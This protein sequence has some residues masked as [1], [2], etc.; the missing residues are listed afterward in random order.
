[1]KKLLTLGLF[2]ILSLSVVG[3]G[4]KL[5]TVQLPAAYVNN[6][7]RED[8]AD[9]LDLENSSKITMNEDGTATVQ[10]TESQ[11]Q[12]ERNELN[13]EYSEEIKDLYSL[14]S[15]DRVQSFVK[16]DYD[17]AYTTFDVYVDSS[18]FQESDKAYAVLLL[19][20]GEVI[21]SFD[22]VTPENIDAIV[23]FIDNETKENIYSV[24]LKEIPR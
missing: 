17:K 19:F 5:V 13:E 18:L 14:D 15:D 16:I 23:N 8:L 22:G 7:S 10:L 6:E 12:E 1:M 11:R 24:S 4:S 20:S 3:C 9:D 2:L 21:Q